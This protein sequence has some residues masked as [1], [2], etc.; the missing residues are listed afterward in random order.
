MRLDKAD[1]KN[2]LRIS[3]EVPHLF[4]S[5]ALIYIF[6]RALDVSTLCH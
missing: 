5:I 6:F 1:G 4:E 2:I 3:R